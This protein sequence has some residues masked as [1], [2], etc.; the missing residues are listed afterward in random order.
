MKDKEKQQKAKDRNDYVPQFILHF[1]A[2]DNEESSK[3]IGT[4]LNYHD[5]SANGP[6]TKD[7]KTPH[8]HQIYYSPKGCHFDLDQSAKCHSFTVTQWFILSMSD[9]LVTQGAKD[10]P[11]GSGFSR[12]AGIYGLHPNVFRIGKDCDVDLSTVWMGMK[13]H[14]NWFC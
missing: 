14:N 6:G 8:V 3:Q 9:R 2:S 1:I 5:P 4:F 13:Q 10:I 11:P 12:Y 7:G